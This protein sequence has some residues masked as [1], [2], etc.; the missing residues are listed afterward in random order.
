MEISSIYLLSEIKT[1]K[2]MNKETKKASEIRYN[3]QVIVTL[4]EKYGLSDYYVRQCVAGRRE[5]IVPDKLQKDYK[6]LTKA[7]ELKKEQF[8]NQL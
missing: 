3:R 1:I 8:K 4:S 2:A 7:L 5:G 6:E